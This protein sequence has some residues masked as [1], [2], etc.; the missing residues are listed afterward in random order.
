MFQ[1]KLTSNIR[2]HWIQTSTLPDQG[3]HSLGAGCLHPWWQHDQA[4]RTHSFDTAAAGSHNTRPCSILHCTCTNLLFGWVCVHT[5]SK[6]KRTERRKKTGDT[7]SSHFVW[8]SKS[9]NTKCIK[10][11]EAAFTQWTVHH[12][13]HNKHLGSVRL[14]FW[15]SNH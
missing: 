3:Q 8:K 12:S 9:A 6:Q 7:F 2:C 11:S 10:R 13:A 1:K 14:F 15:C 5:V 4:D